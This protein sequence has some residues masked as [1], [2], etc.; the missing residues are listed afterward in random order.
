[1]SVVEGQGGKGRDAFVDVGAQLAAAGSSSGLDFL[2]TDACVLVLGVDGVAD[3][4]VAV[5]NAD[6][7]DVSG[8]VSEGD[9]L[10]DVAGEDWGDVAQALEA[11]AIALNFAR[12]LDGQEEFVELL[13]GGG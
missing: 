4:A 3:E 11:D 1:M 10:P 12:C 5:E 8:V 6:L 7:A 2:D 13:E 9:G